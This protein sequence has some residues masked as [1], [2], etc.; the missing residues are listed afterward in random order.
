MRSDG[1]VM[2][3]VLCPAC[4]VKV[5]EE[6]SAG[7]DAHA[8]SPTACGGLTSIGEEAR[9][10]E[11]RARFGHLFR[12]AVRGSGRSQREMMRRI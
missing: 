4:R 8:G 1:V 9:K 11:F 12:P 5:F 10:A 3:R 2:E 7:W 6:W